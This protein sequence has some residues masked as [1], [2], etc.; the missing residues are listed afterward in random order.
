[1][2]RT[3]AALIFLA[4]PTETQGVWIMFCHDTPL[5]INKRGVARIGSGYRVPSRTSL[6]EFEYGWTEYSRRRHYAARS[7]IHCV[8]HAA[9]GVH[10][11][12]ASAA[13]KRSR[14]LAPDD[15]AGHI[16]ELG[17]GWGTARASTL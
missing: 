13:A 3:T 2:Y 1:M 7:H 6:T 9:R 4:S 5:A 17:S 16:Y 15:V 8:G 11:T 14:H 10:L 12:D